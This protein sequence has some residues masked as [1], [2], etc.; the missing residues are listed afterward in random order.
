M[1]KIKNLDDLQIFAKKLTSK[2]KPGDVI[3]LEGDL[4]AGKTTIS[5]MVGRALGVT[6][7]IN[8]PTF[9]IIKSYQGAHMAFHH[10]DCYR[11]ENSDEDLGFDEYFE[12]YAVTMVEW[13]KFIQEYLPHQF[14]QL[15]IRV[16]NDGIRTIQIE[17]SGTHFEHMK[18]YLEH[19]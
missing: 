18:E 1:I 5:Q 11:L 7:T 16:L 17:A 12:D 2:L 3:L 13:S 10:M 6:R 8:S 19:D 4:G 9:N 15:T 14:L